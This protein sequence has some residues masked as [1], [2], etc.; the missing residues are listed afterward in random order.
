MRRNEYEGLGCGRSLNQGWAPSLRSS[1][2]AHTDKPSGFKNKQ[3]DPGAGDA[4]DP[5]H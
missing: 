4:D 3:R 5:A 2:T 1:S